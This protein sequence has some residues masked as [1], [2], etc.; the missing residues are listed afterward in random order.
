M[1]ESVEVFRVS[2]SIVDDFK[3]FIS[4]TTRTH[5]YEYK[6]IPEFRVLDLKKAFGDSVELSEKTEAALEAVAAAAQEQREDAFSEARED[7]RRLIEENIAAAAW[8]ERA[9]QLVRLRYDP[10]FE[11]ALLI[12]RDGTLY[13]RKLALADDSDK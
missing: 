1:P 7:M 8:G 10:Q 9:R 2:D 11:E 4:D 13:Q 3:T 6:A 5:G 12:L